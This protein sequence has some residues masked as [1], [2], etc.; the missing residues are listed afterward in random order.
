MDKKTDRLIHLIKQAQEQYSNEYLV[1]AIPGFISKK[2]I[3]YCAMKEDFE[4]ILEYIGIL[5]QKPI[6]AIKSSLT[7][8]LISLYGKCFTDASK[9][10]FPKLE[11]SD[12]FQEGDGNI[13]T[14]N[15]M[16]ELRH[17]FIAHRGDTE[18]EVGI[19]YM[20]VPKNDKIENSQIRFGQLKQVAFSEEE[21]NKIESLIKFLIAKVL[22]KIQK[23]GQKV[24]DGMLK[25]FTPEQLTLMLM[26][27]A[28]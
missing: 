5:R 17:Q 7:Y 21:I 28:K 18:S 3:A 11:S 2:F 26:N 25:I 8:S 23:S 22:D 24:Y 6:G 10:N 9:N 27:N 15:S 12:L 19:S 13:E 4:L 20:L 1:I 16:M 14:H